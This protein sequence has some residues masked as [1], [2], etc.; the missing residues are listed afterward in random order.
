MRVQALAPPARHPRPRALRMQ[1]H[2]LC[3]RVF[4]GLLAGARAEGK[5]SSKVRARRA[6]ARAHGWHRNPSHRARAAACA[7]RT[8]NPQHAQ[9][10]AVFPRQDKAWVAQHGG[11]AAGAILQGGACGAGACCTQLQDGEVMYGL[12]IK[13]DEGEAVTVY[14]K[15]QLVRDQWVLTL[16]MAAHARQ[17]PM[18]INDRCA[19]RWRRLRAPNGPPTCPQRA[20]GPNTTRTQPGAVVCFTQRA[21]ARAAPPQVHDQLPKAAGHGPVCGGAEGRGEGHRGG[22]A[23]PACAVHAVRALVPTPPCWP[24]AHLAMS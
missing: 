19:L 11:S 14:S 16:N 10:H 20:P 5:L 15:D 13:S 9:S 21:D 6:R 24:R 23:S 17:F 8:D 1:S 22:C 3:K 4:A 7:H 2:T 12:T 18:N